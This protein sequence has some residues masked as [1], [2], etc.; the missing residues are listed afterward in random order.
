MLYLISYDLNVPGQDYADLIRRLT[1]LGAAR[2]LYSQWVLRSQS[3]A[4]DIANDLLRFIDR[5]DRLL[6][7]EIVLANTAFHNLMANLN[8]F[9]AGA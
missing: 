9:A 4:I 3:K 8:A 1:E 5:N 6:V 2:V 7:S